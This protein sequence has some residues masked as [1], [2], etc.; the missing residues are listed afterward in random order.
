MH[1]TLLAAA[2]A[3]VLSVSVPAQ[4]ELNEIYASH[5]GTDTQEFIELEGTPGL[6]LTNYV[7][8]IVEGDGAGAGILDR[9]WDLS[10]F[11]MPA[12]GFF[13]LGD[14][15]VPNVD[16]SIGT[17]DTSENGTETIYL[18]RAN[19]ATDLATLLASLNTQLDP[20]ADLVTTIPTLAT[21]VDHI[22]MTDG[23]A[24]DK[25]FDSARV[26]GPDGTFFPAGIYRGNDAKNDWCN[27]YL[28]FDNVANLKQ[29][30][31]PG[32]AN[33]ICCHPDQGSTQG[34]GTLQLCLCG[35]PF[36]PANALDLVIGGGSPSDPGVLI[37]SD[38]FGGFPFL[39][40]TIGPL[41]ILLSIPITLNGSGGLLVANFY[42]HNGSLA[43]LTAYL[44]VLVVTNVSPLALGGSNTVKLVFLP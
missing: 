6:A 22:G 3:A 15:A 41:P 44:Q 4:V 2:A 21:I 25:I 14:T 17:S 16:L 42:G 30:R 34:P 37:L 27:N 28:D 9:A 8:L 38:T 40:A 35:G 20:D 43:G 1:K 32:V 26:I 11:T 12:D 29:T 18:V 7:V 36:I 39:G 31:T 5:A 19:N 24:T 33:V 10:S 23:G 13:V